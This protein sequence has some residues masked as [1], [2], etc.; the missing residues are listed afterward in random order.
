M[1]SSKKSLLRVTVRRVTK[2]MQKWRRPTHTRGN[3][4]RL[5][6][7]SMELERV[8]ASLEQRRRQSARRDVETSM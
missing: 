1:K 8:L 3:S 4:A 6:T 7:A 5:L 2:W